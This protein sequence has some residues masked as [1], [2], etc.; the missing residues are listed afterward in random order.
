MLADARHHDLAQELRRVLGISS[1]EAEE[2]VQRALDGGPQG[3]ADLLAEALA[4]IPPADPT[5]FLAA[6]GEERPT[7]HR[8]PPPGSPSPPKPPP[9]NKVA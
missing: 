7:R 5:T 8:T 3:I 1:E 9:G 2:R 6:P 4:K